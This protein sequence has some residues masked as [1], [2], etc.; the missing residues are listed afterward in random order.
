MAIKILID[1]GHGGNEP[2]ASANGY[3]EK[4]LTLQESIFLKDEL[5]RCGFDVLMT[6]QSDTF[7]SLDDRGQMAV[8]NNCTCFVSIHFNSMGVGSANKGKGFEAIYSIGNESAKWIALCVMKEASKLGLYE[9]GVWT[10]ES[11]SYPGRNYYGVLR[12]S[13]PLSA[14]ILE[15]LFL[16]N[17][18]DAARLKE[19]D[20]LKKL[21]QA[22]C[23]GLCTA[24]G[25]AYVAEAPQQAENKLTWRDI[26]KLCVSDP[27]AWEKTVT[28]AVEAAKAGGCLGDIETLSFFPI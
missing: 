4:N 6:R 17:D 5:R 28:A 14:V 9:R 25:I 11:D 15:G 22:Y 13:E 18:S 2:G 26:L 3:T 16:D 21:A 1:P 24:Y 8:K 10:K 19:P 23:K 20:F 27:V 12:S 7:V